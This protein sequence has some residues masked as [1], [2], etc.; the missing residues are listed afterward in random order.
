MADEI[1]YT[2]HIA[3]YKADA[4]FQ[5]Y[6]TNNE[7]DEQANRRR[8]EQFSFMYRFNGFE[9]ILEIGSGGGQALKI[10]R[11]HSVRYFPVDIASKNLKMIRAKAESTLFPVSGDT[12]NLPFKKASFDLVILSEVLEHLQD[13][14]AA[15]SEI[16]SVMKNEARLIISVPY[17]EKISY[18]LCI[19]CNKPT[20]TFAHLHSFDEQKLNLLLFEAGLEAE[21]TIKLGNKVANRLHINIL[22]KRF[23]F[24]MWKFFD[25]LFNIILPKPSHL[26]VLANK[27]V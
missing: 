18:Q 11:N 21:R 19:H 15:L 14:L 2:N 5:D 27:K 4:E 17:K 8:Y 6:F 7:F 10:I 12:F 16:K 9:R 22:L 26:I 25:S 23:P 3:H 13:T 24:I 20:P 1:K